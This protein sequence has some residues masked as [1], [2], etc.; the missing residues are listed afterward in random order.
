MKTPGTL[1]LA[2]FLGLC[3]A[4]HCEATIYNSDGSAANVQ[5]LTNIATDGDTITL[6]VGTF[7]WATTVTISKAITLQGQTTTDSVA[8]T[9]N[10]QTIILDD[11]SRSTPS[12][13]I[14]IHITD[15]SARVSGLTFKP[16]IVT[17]V[18][19]AGAIQVGGTVTNPGFRIDHCNF[20]DGLLNVINVWVVGW[21]YG[22]VDHCVMKWTRTDIGSNQSCE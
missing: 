13:G 17:Q 14:I 7:S 5:A 2:L 10:D 9:A 12:Y 18:A 19:S 16:D 20:Y 15:A 22:V 11:V 21:T 4:S 1:L 8:G 6:P 3:L